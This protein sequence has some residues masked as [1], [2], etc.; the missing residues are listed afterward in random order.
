MNVIN[1]IMNK[2][3]REVIHKIMFFISVPVAD[4]FKLELEAATNK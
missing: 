4:I 3:P 1:Y 2:L